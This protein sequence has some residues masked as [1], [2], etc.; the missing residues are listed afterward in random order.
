MNKT[1]LR[2]A[3]VFHAIATEG[4]IAAAARR[5][6]KSPPAVHHDLKRFEADIGRPLFKRVGRG[7][8]LTAEGRALHET[9]ARALDDIERTRNRI[10]S[11]DPALKPLRLG[12]VS[13]FGRY[14]LAPRLFATLNRARPAELLFDEHDSLI[15]ALQRGRI[16][17][18]VTYRPVA[19]TPVRCEPVAEE[20]IVLAAACG[21]E[22]PAALDDISR[23]VFVTYDEYEYVFAVWFE[24]VFGAQPAALRRA[25]HVTELEEAMESAAAGRGATIVPR[26]ALINGPWRNRLRELRPGGKV[27]TNTL[28]LLNMGASTADAELLRGLLSRDRAPASAASTEL[29]GAALS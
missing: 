21:C 16:D 28:Y 10:A 19:M 11:S 29:T 7:L 12:V 1:E 2:R 4:S 26:D 15:E 18:A 20:H 14:R 6:C 24:A 13:G 8:R 3:A 23:T 25:D 5:L 17:W 22:P 9:V 27:A